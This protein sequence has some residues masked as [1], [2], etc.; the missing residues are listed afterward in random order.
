M[1][2]TRTKSCSLASNQEKNDWLPQQVHSFAIRQVSDAC[3]NA[4]DV[5]IQIDF[6][7][8]DAVVG[9]LLQPATTLPLNHRVLTVENVF[10]FMSQWVSLS[11]SLSSAGKLH[12]LSKMMGKVR[13]NVS[14]FDPIMCS[15]TLTQS[16]LK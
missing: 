14:N 1:Y 13:C 3:Q 11:L 12:F 5:D 16:S 15:I 2:G 10:R 9:Q 4:K 7:S 8:S 6:I